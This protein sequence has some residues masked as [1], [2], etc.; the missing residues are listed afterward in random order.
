MRQTL[1]ITRYTAL[2]TLR[3]RTALSAAATVVLLF[4]ASFF[5]R[6]IAIADSLRLQ[7]TFLAASGRLACVFIASVLI[8]SAVVREFNEKGHL[9][10]LSLDLGRTQYVLG[11]FFGFALPLALLCGGM[12]VLVGVVGGF[13]PAV[14]WAF[15]LVLEISL[16]A[17]VSLFCAL[18]MRQVLPATLL[19]VGFYLLARSIGGIQLLA[20]SGLAA[21]QGTGQQVVGRIVDG[22]ALLLPRLDLFAASARLVDNAAAGI[23]AVLVQTAL[24]CALLLAAASIDVARRDL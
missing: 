3:A 8:I 7:T 6:E 19:T 5:V 13:A 24:Y 16:M 22:L 9:L 2:E 20:H 1:T 14:F 23:S 11:K 10:L 12:G 15:T 17:A 4:A 18:S 21:G